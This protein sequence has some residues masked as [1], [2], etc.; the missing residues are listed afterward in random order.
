MNALSWQDAAAAAVAAGAL[1]WLVVRR[2]R[3][4]GKSEACESC[5]A[6][7]PVPGVRP[8]PVPGLLVSIGEPPARAPGPR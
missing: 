5:P 6:A 4:R 1:G 3:R 2:L 7:H 8:A